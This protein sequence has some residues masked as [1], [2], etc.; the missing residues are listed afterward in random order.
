MKD[1]LLV[2]TITPVLNRAEY[3]EECIESVLKQDYSNVEHVLVDGGSTDGSLDIL[4]EYR[5][6]YPKRVRYISEKDRGA[7]DAINKGLRMA[8]GQI[9]GFLGSDDTYPTDAISKVIKAFSEY[10]DVGLIYGN[11]NIIDGRGQF[12]HLAYAAD[13]D[14]EEA[15]HSYCAMFSPSMFYKKEVIDKIGYMD[16]T[17]HVGDFDLILRASRIF[18][19]QRI[20]EVLSNFRMHK[21]SVTCSRSAVYMYAWENFKVARRY[22]AKI[23][24]PRARSLVVTCLT[25]P[26]RPILAPIYHNKVLY[27]T[28]SRLIHKVIGGRPPK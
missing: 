3:L 13:F 24:G 10:P 14:R 15:I 8:K 6:R 1:R 28:L 12:T 22:G 27:P 7:C 11:C 17:L 26:F 2:S 5:R 19:F 9:L 21:G 4:E 25:Q 18:V 16:W 23:Y 20:D